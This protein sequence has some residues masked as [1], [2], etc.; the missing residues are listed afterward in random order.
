[1]TRALRRAS[2]VVAA[3]AALTVAGCSSGHSTAK[4]VTVPPPAPAASGDRVPSLK[5]IPPGHPGT[6]P[7]PL[8]A[9]SSVKGDDPEAVSRAVVT[10]QWTVDTSIDN[11]RH[12]AALRAAP[13]LEPAYLAFLK[14]HPPVAAPGAEWAEW[15]RHRAYTTVA[16]RALH[17]ERPADSATEARR[18]WLVTTTPRGRDGWSGRPTT[19]TAFVTMT[20]ERAGAPWRVSGITVSS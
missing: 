1:M 16:T 3:L 18:Q 14:A 13:F 6:P 7:V 15:T 20:R 10:I 12:D 17:D 11:S 9:P 4:P 5:P 19:T 2:A 8:P